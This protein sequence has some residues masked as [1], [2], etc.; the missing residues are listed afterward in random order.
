MGE[1]V[2]LSE[3]VS[4]EREAEKL[5]LRQIHCCA[6]DM[7]PPKVENYTFFFTAGTA[8]VTNAHEPIRR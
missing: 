3:R 5:I 6:P 1:R 2:E 7:T 4:L 8:L